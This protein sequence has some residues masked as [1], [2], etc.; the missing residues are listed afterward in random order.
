M[1]IVSLNW[2]LG[3]WVWDEYSSRCRFLS[4][5][6]FDGV[7]FLGFCFL[8]CLLVFVAWIS[9][10]W[11]D[12]W[13]SRESLSKLGAGLLVARLAFDAARSL[14]Q[15][16]KWDMVIRKGVGVVGSEWIC[17]WQ[18]WSMV[19]HGIFAW[20]C[21]TNRESLPEF[22]YL[23]F[24]LAWSAPV[25]QTVMACTRWMAWPASG[26]W[27]SAGVGGRGKSAGQEVGQDR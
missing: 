15:S 22:A 12:F 5:S 23:F 18:V 11:L 24:W 20:V 2:H 27:K 17:W 10:G 26:Q 9:G 21:L 16:G 7:L 13:S 8:F 19:Q 25:P 6:L 14:S 3:L 4:L 1:L